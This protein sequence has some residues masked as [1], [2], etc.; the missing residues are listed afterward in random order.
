MK[1]TTFPLDA[2][3]PQGSVGRPLLF[4]LYSNDLTLYIKELDIVLYAD[5][6]VFVLVGADVSLLFQTMNEK[7]AQLDVWCR[8]NGLHLNTEKTKYMT[9]SNK[10]M[11]IPNLQ[12]KINTNE[13]EQVAT[14]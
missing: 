3:V 8:Y 10:I 1:S 7:L 5:D 2:S 4:N 13:I 12:L 11:S 9:F 14:F 6:S